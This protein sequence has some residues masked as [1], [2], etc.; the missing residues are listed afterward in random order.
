MTLRHSLSKSLGSELHGIQQY[1]SAEIPLCVDDMHTC[2]IPTSRSTLVPSAVEIRDSPRN[3]DSSTVADIAESLLL[4]MSLNARTN[5]IQ[6]T[7]V[8][9]LL[10]H[11]TLCRAQCPSA[12]YAPPYHS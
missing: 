5:W 9:K 11:L 12:L 4:N 6:I 8:D 2:N 3:L 7:I 10:A 1:Q